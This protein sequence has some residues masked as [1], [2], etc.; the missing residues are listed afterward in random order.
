MYRVLYIVFYTFLL[1]GLSSCGSYVKLYDKG[2]NKAVVR[3]LKNKALK[4]NLK[5]EE[6]AVF[7]QALQNDLLEE[8]KSLNSNLASAE[9]EDWKDGFSHLD[10]LEKKQRNYQNFPQ[11]NL[12][13]FEFIDIAYWDQAFSDKLYTHHISSYS[14]HYEK[15]LET[16]DKNHI[17]DAFYE[18]EKVAYFEEDNL[19]TD[20]LM[21]VFAKLGKRTFQVKYHDQ[22]F[23]PWELQRLNAN[24]YLSSHQWSDFFVESPYDY[25]VNIT[26]K[27]LDKDDS[28]SQSQRA[29]TNE[30]ITGYNAVADPNGGE[31][32]QVP[33]IEIYTASVNETAFTYRVSTTVEVEIVF[34]ETGQRM[35]YNSFSENVYDE[36]YE[37]YLISGDLRAIPQDVNLTNGSAILS[38][39]S[40]DYNNMVEEVLQNI[41]RDLKNYIERY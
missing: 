18:L 30:V 19:N 37:A 28:Y 2:N 11:V 34:N 14:D 13:E 24:L 41:G 40:Y 16:N 6:L 39:G 21:H 4:G 29:Y 33:I 15:Y 9:F 17:I 38:S 23:S 10:N 3:N 25:T 26:L 36:R 8:L 7:E 5:K 35:A 31:V 27:A 22:A 20:S 32:V 1:S 12:D